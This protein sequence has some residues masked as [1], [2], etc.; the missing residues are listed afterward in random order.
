ML[1]HA[2]SHPDIF[3]TKDN[4]IT[5]LVA[6]QIEASFSWSVDELAELVHSIETMDDGGVDWQRGG[7]GQSLWSIMVVDTDLCTKLPAA[8]RH[9]V[10]SKRL[11]AA[12]RLVVCHQYLADDP[13]AAVDAIM[14]EYPA[15]GRVSQ[16]AS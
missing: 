2:T 7:V 16:I 5:P 11:E 6:R 15:L 13:V 12:A 3:W 10:E 9:C 1:A 8:I 14:A 4:W